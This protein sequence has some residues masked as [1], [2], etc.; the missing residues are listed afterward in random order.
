MKD[1]I[2]NYAILHKYFEIILIHMFGSTL[3]SFILSPTREVHILF[4][5]CFPIQNYFTLTEAK[6]IIC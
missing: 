6:Q 1:N 3:V 5:F 2:V 4:F